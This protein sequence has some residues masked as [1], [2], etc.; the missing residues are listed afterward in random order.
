MALTE[1]GLVKEITVHN[2]WVLCEVP[3][4]QDKVEGTSLNLDL[5]PELIAKN[6]QELSSRW[7]YKVVGV[8][9]LCTNVKIGDKIF[10]PSAVLQYV[11]PKSKE[12]VFCQEGSVMGSIQKEP[13]DLPHPLP[14]H[15]SMSKGE[16]LQAAKGKNLT[17]MDE[18]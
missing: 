3:K 8:G 10:M 2:D 1:K 11:D 17:D 5:P 7:L 15:Y 16:A 6:E 12:L 13:F 4:V 18:G 9:H 14:V